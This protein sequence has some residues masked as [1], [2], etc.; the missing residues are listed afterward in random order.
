MPT[1]SALYSRELCVINQHRG[2]GKMAHSA[3]YEKA[4][5][6]DMYVPFPRLYI[7]IILLSGRW[8]P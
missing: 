6:P 3:A 5:E 7:L 8:S 4:G 2:R 1:G